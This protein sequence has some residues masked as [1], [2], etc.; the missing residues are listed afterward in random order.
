MTPILS[1]CAGVRYHG[2]T[3]QVLQIPLPAILVDMLGATI[4]RLNLKK[5]VSFKFHRK[6]LF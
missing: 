5:S 2:K 3:A 1:R 4:R 6:L